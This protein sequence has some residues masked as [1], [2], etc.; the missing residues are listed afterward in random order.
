LHLLGDHLAERA[1]FA[2]FG[3]IAIGLQT[4]FDK[5]QSAFFQVI[6]TNLTQLAPSFD[7]EPIGGLFGFS[8]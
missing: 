5:D 2:A 6:L 3:F 1:S 8:L 7:I 4:T